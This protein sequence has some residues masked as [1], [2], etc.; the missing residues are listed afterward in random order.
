MPGVGANRSRTT[1][2]SRNMASIVRLGNDD[3]DV[4]DASS[5]RFSVVVLPNDV[6][7]NGAAVYS[8]TVTVP[9]KKKRATNT[10][11]DAYMVCVD[12]H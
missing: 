3:D 5:T 6:S 11:V 9:E 1:S 7:F 12:E 10:I 2:S 4:D 8:A